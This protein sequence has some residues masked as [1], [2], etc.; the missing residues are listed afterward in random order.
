MPGSVLHPEH[1]AVAR[2]PGIVDQDMNPLNFASI[3][4]TTRWTSADSA[5]LAAYPSA[6]PPAS[7]I[8][9]SVG[10]QT[11]ERAGHAGDRRSA[12]GQPDRDR[13]ADAPRRARDQR[14]LARQI[15]S[16]AR[17]SSARALGHDRDILTE[18]C[19]DPV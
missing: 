12:S 10:L 16:T 17:G 15:D 9:W 18:C 11:V 2:D 13:P 6:V 7:R 3:S 5:T 19:F 8:A 14:H 4:S 1:Q